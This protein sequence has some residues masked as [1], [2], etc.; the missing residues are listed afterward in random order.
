MI[1]IKTTPKLNGITI[2]GDYDDLFHLYDAVSEYINFYIDGI[3]HEI[4]A[5]YVKA[6]GVAVADMNPKQR[7]EFF[8]LNQS[9]ITYFEEL[10][11]NILGLCYDIRHAYQGDRGI[12]IVENGQDLVNDVDDDIPFANLQFCVEVLYPWAFYYLFALQD[13]LDNYYKPEWL[14]GI[15]EYGATY[16]E[17]DIHLY[18]SAVETFVALMWKN[19][20]ALFG[21][22]FETLYT[23]FRY[24]DSSALLD[25]AYLTGICSYL[26]ADNCEGLSKVK[27]TNFKKNIL[28]VLAYDSMDSDNLYD[29]DYSK[30]AYVIASKKQYNKALE[31]VNKNATI[32]YST[33]RAFMSELLKLASCATEEVAEEWV[34]KIFGKADWDNLEW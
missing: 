3:M 27:Y 30:E 17:V 14:N 31:Y 32:P 12:C 4:E 24:K 2:Q 9:E 5:D 8:A 34:T 22:D 15:G 10:R 21:K 33:S 6:H 13:I 19:L 28:L 29:S 23:Y 20:E 7:E 16:K 25:R 26:V 18:R 11:E 1:S